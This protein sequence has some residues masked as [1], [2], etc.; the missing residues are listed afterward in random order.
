L[1]VHAS[2]FEYLSNL[3]GGDEI[4]SAYR[5][6]KAADNACAFK[7]NG[8][9]K[10]GLSLEDDLVKLFANLKRSIIARNI[11]P[12]TLYR[13]TSDLE[14]IA[15][16]LHILYG[17]PLRYAA[18]MSAT[19]TTSNLTNFMPAHGEPLVL[20]IRCPPLTC[21]ALMEAKPGMSEDE[22][23]LGCGTEFSVIERPTRLQSAEAAALLGIN[24][25]LDA[26]Q[27]LKLSIH[28]SPAY[29]KANAQFFDF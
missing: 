10:A 24:T 8:C 5:Q 17:L 18:F 29:A 11:E 13:M 26:I 12:L 9:L 22:Y 2:F 1:N 19:A 4:Q 15:P 23:L 25:G 28:S 6:Y 21:M 7:L 27:Y 14:F 3:P 20:E 16:V